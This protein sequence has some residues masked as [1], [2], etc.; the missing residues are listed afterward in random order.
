MSRIVRQT[1]SL[2]PRLVPGQLAAAGQPA[3]AKIGASASVDLGQRPAQL[4][5][6]LAAHLHEPVQQLDAI[7]VDDQRGAVA[8]VQHASGLADRLLGQLD[9]STGH[10]AGA[11][12]DEGKVDW[13]PFGTRCDRDLGRDNADHEGG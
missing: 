8:A 3:A 9:R 12:D 5:A 11:I 7:V 4:A 1:R 6:P 10:G 2:P 13:R